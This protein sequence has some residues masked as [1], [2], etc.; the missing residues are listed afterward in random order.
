MS[1][2]NKKK[3][4]TISI[5]AVIL[6]ALI[7]VYVLVI[8]PLTKEDD[9]T[10][11]T[12]PEI[13]EGEGLFNGS[14]ITIYPQLDKT[15]IE[16]LEITNKYGT[17]G[18]HK[19]YDSTM[20]KE[21]MRLK[22]YEGID[23]D[24]SLYALLIAYV[25]LPVSYGSSE[26]EGAP[27]RDVDK[28]QMEEMG[29]TKE[30]CQASYTVGYLENGE[31][32]YHTV[33][34][35][36]PTL[37]DETTYY[38]ALEGRNTIYRF[39]QEGVETCL[40]ASMLDYI[41]PLIYGKFKNGTEAMINVER[42]KLGFSNLE[43]G[44]DSIIEIVKTGQNADGTSNTYD[45]LYKSK[46]TGN[47]VRIGAGVNN[48]SNVFTA[49]FCRFAGDKV[50]CV[51]PTQE[52]L[53]EYGLGEN[54]H[55]YYVTAQL[56]SDKEDMCTFRI[57]DLKDG[58]YY[59][60]SGIYGTDY[61]TLV[62]VPKEALF[63]LGNDD[64]TVFSWAGTDVSS[65]FYEYLLPNDDAKEPGLR[66]L[67]IKI[68]KKDD[69]T[70]EIIYSIMESFNISQD[71]NGDALVECSNGLVYKMINDQNEFTD[72]YTLLI[73]FPAPT[74]FNN[75]TKEEISNVKNGKNSLVFELISRNNDN[76]LLRF[77]YYQIENSMDIM[78]ESCKGKMENGQ[79]VWDEAQV[80]FNTYLSQIDIL[81]NEFQKLING[82][83]VRPEDYI[84]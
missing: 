82:E 35:G 84:Y 78:I 59:T 47:I 48:L 1:Q 68:Q 53:K 46:G 52:Q 6:L 40:L 64:K 83:N 37:T 36:N 8:I 17:Y 27:M 70:G 62:R 65:L 63:F 50:V 51:K 44:L 20:E 12:P 56:S 73:Y 10:P 3:I 34:I 16:S 13:V 28:K 79:E 41:S 74:E 5:L 18:F 33:Y 11:N 31:K 25:Y 77:S 66:D 58:Y 14:M 69:K 2:E 81:R 19:Y 38:V 29:V 24:E 15:N 26:P 21:E 76:E 72:F 39:H 9:P 23:Y 71:G 32:K 75:L 54:D 43:D 80:S 61:P 42:L 49:L 57:S 55:C 7:L 67:S 45:L 30:T 60:L 4:I 22:G